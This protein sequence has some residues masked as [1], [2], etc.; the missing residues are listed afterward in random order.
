[1]RLLFFSMWY[2]PEPVGKPH[3]LAKELK[4]LGHDVTVVTG[5]PNYPEGSVYPDY[6]KLVLFSSRGSMASR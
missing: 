1:M 6:R 4:A 2:T 3:S 5:F